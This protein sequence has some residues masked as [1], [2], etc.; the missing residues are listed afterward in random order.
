MTILAILFPLFI[1]LLIPLRAWI[2]KFISPEFLEI[3][4]WE[5]EG[6]PPTLQ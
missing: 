4:D 5:E 2:V 1:L 6:S 3:L